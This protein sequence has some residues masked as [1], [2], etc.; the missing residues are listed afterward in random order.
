MNDTR[1]PAGAVPGRRGAI[2]REAVPM[3]FPSTLRRAY[4]GRAL[5][6]CLYTLLS[7]PMAVIGLGAVIATLVL[8]ILSAIVIIVPLLPIFLAFDRSLGGLHRALGRRLLR[9]DV[10]KPVRAPRKRGLLGF[11]VYH[12]AD[13]VAWRAVAYLA[14]RYPLGIIEFTLGFVPWLYS[15]LFI[16]AP[17]IRIVSPEYQ[18]DSH[19]V[20]HDSFVQFGNF[21]FDTD[22]KALLLTAAGVLLLLAAPWMT[23]GVLFFDRWLLPRLLGPTDSSL[24]I[25]ELEKTRSHAINEAALTLRRVERDLHDGAQARLVALG[26]RLGRAET[27][28]ERNDP[29]QAA[30]LVREA[31]EEVK[32]IIA[33]LREL[34]RGIHPPA[35]DAGLEAALATLAARSPVPATVRVDLP[36]RPA[37]SIET[38]L[39]FA[40]AE[41][42]TNIG[43]HSHAT[44]CSIGVTTDGHVLRLTVADDGA[45]GAS[46]EGP[47]SGLR[48]LAER[49]RTTDGSL[50][51]DS[52][53]GGPTEVT[54][55]MPYA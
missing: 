25:Q 51:V 43:K 34:V 6:E 22:A 31:R 2:R 52:P 33:E 5:R 42:L 1:F 19:G 44:W 46:L 9:V 41:L 30:V 18:T 20:R 27:R 53:P 15:L 49:V 3:T 14:L 10:A 55:S 29:A 13:A 50:A 37:A 16:A 32:G 35:L 28:L 47:G 26:M 4:G 11:L 40:A 8:G 38:M 17:V 21:Y 48:G 54:V 36:H 7:L 12:L 39:Y 45:G 24:R 23:H